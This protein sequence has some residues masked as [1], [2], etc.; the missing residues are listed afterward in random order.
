MN[1][2]I[3]GG[4]GFIGCN[5][6]DAF[7]EKAVITVF[8]NL[9]RRGAEVN[10]AWLRSRNPRLKFVH[11]DLRNY[12]DLCR[13]ASRR[14]L[15]SADAVF[16]LAGQVAVTTSV[17]NPREDFENNA[18]GAFN[19]I[20]AL[21]DFGRDRGRHAAVIYASTNKVYGAMEQTKIRLKKTKNLQRY[22]YAHLP[23]GVAE[24]ANLDFH[25]PYG[26]SK[27]YADQ[28]VR[29]VARPD[30]YGMKTVVLR[31]SCIYGPRQFGVED[32]GW[33]AWFSIAAALD[34]PIA[35]YGDGRQTRDVLYIDD[36]AEAYALA[37]RHADRIKGE[38]FN[39]GGGPDNAMSLLELVRYLGE[40]FG[41][42]PAL[43]FADWRPGDQ[44]CFISD[45]RK[46]RQSFGWAPSIG[47]RAGI[48]RLNEWI[49]T[50][51]RNDPRVFDFLRKA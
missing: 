12:N 18:L 41:R 10:L 17:A 32:Q 36:L 11:A 21:R 2:L 51:L 48:E 26:C 37:V 46:A 23:R 44:R 50:M 1:I 43:S 28:Y 30:I 13:P 22:E 31:Q 38:I 6:A 4:A 42:K 47:V 49:Q 3:T 29:D 39:I 9:S 19:L 20:Q 35:I 14:A 7:R 24:S 8:D 34:M 16:H 45:I 5:M 40:F 15:A 33:V 25:S 27:G